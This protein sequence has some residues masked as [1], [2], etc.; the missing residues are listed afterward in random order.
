MIKALVMAAGVGDRAKLGYNKLL[1]EFDGASILEHTLRAVSTVADEIVVVCNLAEID[2]IGKTA[3]KF[4]ASVTAGGT[5][6]TDSVRAGLE[7]L[8]ESATAND[9][10]IIHDGAR[11][12][13]TREVFEASI[14]S[15]K[16]NGSGI[17]SVPAVDSMRERVGV[18]GYRSKIVDRN[19]LIVIQSPQTFNLVKVLQAYDNVQ[20]NFGD[21]AEVYEKFW[22]SVTLS[23][24]SRAN[25]KIT[26]EDDLADLV[27]K[28]ARVGN[29]YDTHELVE[30]RKLI[31]GGVDVPHTKGLLGHSDA[32]VL[33]HAIMDALLSAIGERDIGVHFPDTDA[34]YKGISSMV[35]L[36]RVMELVRE[37]G[38][39]VKNASAVLMAQKPKLS[40]YVQEMKK[41]LAHVLGVDVGC[42]GLSVTTTE[43]LG[44]VGRE[45]GIACYATVLLRS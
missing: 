22:G 29:G 25:I 10:V 19:K 44:F 42:V 15:A 30:G 20:G 8:R 16:K 39:A 24:G 26:T 23:I 35:L 13:A 34:Q 45:E 33:V 38:F 28:T 5:T 37:G 41:N 4:G 32:D 40:P 27:A 18:L 1:F 31:L 21:D 36:K 14:T 2:L 11:P 3:E 12:F 7:S 17:A 6:R 9:I 43:G